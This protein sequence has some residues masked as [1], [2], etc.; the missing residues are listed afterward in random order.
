MLG[1]GSRTLPASR[2]TRRVAP[3]PQVADCPGAVPAGRGQR[4][5]LRLGDLRRG[6]WGRQRVSGWAG[7]AALCGRGALLM[8]VLHQAPGRLAP[9]SARRPG[10]LQLA[11]QPTSLVL[12]PTAAS[13]AGRARLEVQGGAGVGVLWE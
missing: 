2:H 12:D 3:P 9:Q 5:A 8:V 1:R 11:V 13:D 10:P 4:T 6:L 7:Q